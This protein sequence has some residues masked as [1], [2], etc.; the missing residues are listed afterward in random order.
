MT[1][2]YENCVPIETIVSKNE[3]TLYRMQKTFK[4]VNTL[5]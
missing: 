4:I 5:Y 3:L 1:E 2:I